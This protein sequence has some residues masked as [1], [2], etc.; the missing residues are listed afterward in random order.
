MKK[1]SKRDYIVSAGI[2]PVRIVNE[3]PLFLMLRA[4][5]FWDFP[6]GRKE[7]GESDLETAVRETMEEASIPP[8]RITFPWGKDCIETEPYRKKKD[9]VGR[10]FVGLTD[11]TDIDLPVNPEL[12]RAEHEE[13]KWVTYEEA[14]EMTNTRIGSVVDWAYRK[15]TSTE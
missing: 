10:Y 4:R 14:K 7:K 3:E 9:K 8:D 6:K 11:F 1:I 13:F 15:I 5:T 2:V 12:G